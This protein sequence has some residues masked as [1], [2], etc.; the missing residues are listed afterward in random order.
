[1]DLSQGSTS[2]K[3]T[4]EN[5]DGRRCPRCGKRF[6]TISSMNR[7]VRM[8]HQ[9]AAAMEKKKNHVLCPSVD[10][11]ELMFQTFNDLSKHIEEFHKVCLQK[12]VFSLSSQQQYEEWVKLEKIDSNYALIR[13]RHEQNYKQK[14][15][16]CNRSDTK[17]LI[18][19]QNSLRKT[20]RARKMIHRFS[21]TLTV[22]FIYV[23][24]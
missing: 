6:A 18:L 13:T 1:M 17:L 20:S 24:N 21:K 16:S 12:L 22:T 3:Q 4:P 8:I 19:L 11:R 10:C 9:E 23:N 2:Q 14:E 15:Y 7:H 5:V